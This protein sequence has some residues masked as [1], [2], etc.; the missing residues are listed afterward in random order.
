MFFFTINIEWCMFH[1]DVAPV[2]PPIL[3]IWLGAHLLHLAD[4]MV[5]S[6][7]AGTICN[8]TLSLG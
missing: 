8:Q 2:M 4:N 7:Q 3:E 1:P 6:G 5:N